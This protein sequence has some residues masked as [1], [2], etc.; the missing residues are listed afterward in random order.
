VLVLW[1]FN[2]EIEYLPTRIRP[3]LRKYSKS[4][5]AHSRRRR[6][7]CRRME[8]SRWFEA[9]SKYVPSSLLSVEGA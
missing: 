8:S 5:R 6:S 1:C 2:E 4:A 9:C 7:G 3:T